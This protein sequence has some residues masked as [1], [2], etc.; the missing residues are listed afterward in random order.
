MYFQFQYSQ[1]ENPLHVLSIP[2]QPVRKPFTCTFNSNTANQKIL[3]MYFQFQYSQSENPL[4]ILRY[5]TGCNHQSSRSLLNKNCQE[6]LC[7]HQIR[8]R[9]VSRKIYPN[10]IF[11][12]YKLA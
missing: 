3:Y 9:E 12:L 7:K 11:L 2:I 8:H 6:L 5:A 1:S 4:N 10:V